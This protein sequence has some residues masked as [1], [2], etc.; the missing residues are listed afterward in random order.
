MIVCHKRLS[1]GCCDVNQR[2][3]MLSSAISSLDIGI[4]SE[5]NICIVVQKVPINRSLE[6]SK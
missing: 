5:D 4:L 1:I 3:P 6:E 2:K